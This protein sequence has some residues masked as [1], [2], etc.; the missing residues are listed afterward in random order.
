[1]ARMVNGRGRHQRGMKTVRDRSASRIRARG[2][3]SCS[4]MRKT[5]PV[6]LALIAVVPSTC[7]CQPSMVRFSSPLCGVKISWPPSSEMFTLSSCRAAPPK[8]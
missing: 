5:F 7:A 2:S 1:M 3:P 8:R 4:L 6:A